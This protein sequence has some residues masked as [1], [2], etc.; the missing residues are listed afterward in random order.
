MKKIDIIQLESLETVLH[1]VKDVL[2]TQVSINNSQGGCTSNFTTQSTLIDVAHLVNFIAQH[3]R[4][5]GFS[6][7]RTIKLRRF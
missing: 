4:V 2:H 3:K 5:Y 7:N 6:R 1:G